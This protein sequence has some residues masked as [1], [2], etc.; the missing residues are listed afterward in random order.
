[1]SLEMHATL[2]VVVTQSVTRQTLLPLTGV[3]SHL[4][5]TSTWYVF[6]FSFKITCDLLL[7]LNYKNVQTNKTRETWKQCRYKKHLLLF[8]SAVWTLSTVYRRR[9]FWQRIQ[10]TRHK[11]HKMDCFV[12]TKTTVSTL[13]VLSFQ[14]EWNQIWTSECWRYFQ[15]LSLWQYL[16]C[17]C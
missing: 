13:A 15:F 7:W 14:L 11:K 17:K 9:W 6:E 5:G 8:V 12:Y 1:M 4:S 3:K 10:S 16:I 2:I